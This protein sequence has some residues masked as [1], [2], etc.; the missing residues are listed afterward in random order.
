MAT[1]D[2]FEILEE[3]AVKLRNAD[4][5]TTTQRGVTTTTVTGTLAGSTT[6][7]VA[8]PNVKNI[9]SFLVD[10]TTLTLGT[11]YETN[12]NSGSNCV[13]TFTTAQTGT[14]SVNYDYGGDH[15]WPGYP[16]QDINIS[17]IPQIAVEFID[18]T[19]E[20]GGFGN[21]NRNSYDLSI[22][23][24]DFKKEDVRNYVKAI[25]SFLLSNM[26][27]FNKLRVVKPRMIGPIVP[28]EFE[29]FKDR[30]FKQ[31]IDFNSDFNLEIN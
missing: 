16:R 5:L 4:V 15:I 9:R 2:Q 28:A 31:N 10:A 20:N 21:V 8:V 19:S 7:T 18:V 23:V 13:V 24:Y 26:N 17:A 14:A 11:D 6:F 27:G 1:L 30:V 3:V 22:V 29:K 12:Y 25:R